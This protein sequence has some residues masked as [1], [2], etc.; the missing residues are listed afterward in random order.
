MSTRRQ[1]LKARAELAGARITITGLADLAERRLRQIGQLCAEKSDLRDEN[2]ALRRDLAE[3]TT[4][5]AGWIAERRQL[6]ERIMALAGR[7]DE[8]QR[9]NEALCR[10][11]VDRTRVGVSA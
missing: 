5:A 6:R 2:E 7:L 9:A 1:L 11:A 10:E 3:V 4:P 8:A